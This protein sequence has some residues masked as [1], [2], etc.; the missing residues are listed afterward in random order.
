MACSSLNPSESAYP[1]NQLSADAAAFDPVGFGEGNTEGEQNQQQRQAR[2]EEACGSGI[3]DRPTCPAAAK[4]QAAKTA[5]LSVAPNEVAVGGVAR[6]LPGKSGQAYGRGDIIACSIFGA[7]GLAAVAVVAVLVQ[8]LLSLWSDR[9]LPD[10]PKVSTSYQLFCSCPATCDTC[11][12]R[13]LVGLSLGIF[14]A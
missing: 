8:R 13:N 10:P 2:D 11:C 12:C 1:H 5:R 14:Y 7:I 9:T 3:V 4:A 6:A